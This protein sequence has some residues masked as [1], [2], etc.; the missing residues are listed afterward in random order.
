MVTFCLFGGGTL[1]CRDPK[2]TGSASIGSALAA[3]MKFL[4]VS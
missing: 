4:P 2:V 1:G 3:A